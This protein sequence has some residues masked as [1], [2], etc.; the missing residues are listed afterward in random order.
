M[1]VPP[2]SIMAMLRGGLNTA[3]NGTPSPYLEPQEQSAVNA[4]RRQA[5]I[6]A[7]LQAAAPRP[8]GTGNTL[9]DFG[10][11]LAA[12]Q[13]AQAS[14][15]DDAMKARLTGM[16][17]QQMRAQSIAAQQR[18]DAEAARANKPNVVDG[19]LVTNEGRVIYSKPDKPDTS[20]AAKKVRDLE[21]QLGRRLTDPERLD[22]FGIKPTEAKIDESDK[23]LSPADL[24]RLRT[25]DGQ[26]FP[27]GTTGR[28]AAAAGAKSYSD[29]EL[30]RQVNTS[31]ALNTLSEI[32]QLALGKNG[33]F[34]DNGGSPLTN[35]A[36]ARLANGISNGIGAFFGTDASVRRDVFNSTAQGSISS[37]VRSM[38]EAGSLSD[39]DVKRALSL[40][41]VLG[42]TPDTEATAKVKFEEL[43]RIIS[44]GASGLTASAP[45]NGV[46]EADITETM[47]ANN[48]T[49]EQVLQ[50]LNAR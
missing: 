40:V 20:E 43:Q 9:G 19:S 28:Q 25:A 14:G 15:F 18:A 12:G 39:G 26:S 50:R 48:M 13:H 30:T 47:R 2:N 16:Q 42:A 35:N 6:A 27:F 11:A 46:T 8:Q 36:L 10:N 4:Q 41:P 37:L 33:A 1:S 24:A 44:R 3:V 49:R 45:L 7:L 32:K 22:L 38:G 21:T 29:T 17:I 23:P 31:T 5:M 34:V